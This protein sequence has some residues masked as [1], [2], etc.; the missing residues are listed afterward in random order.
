MQPLLYSSTASSPHRAASHHLLLTFI[1]PSLPPSGGSPFFFFIRR[2]LQPHAA[3]SLC[4]GAPPRKLSAAAWH[5]QLQL[6]SQDPEKLTRLLTSNALRAASNSHHRISGCAHQKKHPHRPLTSPVGTPGWLSASYL[7]YICSFASSS[8]PFCLF[9]IKYLVLLCW[10]AIRL[11]LR[12]LTRLNIVFTSLSPG[13][14]L[15]S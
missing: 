4:A 8:L 12:H 10:R 6:M 9:P 5:V 3:A 14:M 11:P 7:M 15:A 2:M 1:A 13:P